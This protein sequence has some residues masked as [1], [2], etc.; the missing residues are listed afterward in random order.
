M[1]RVTLNPKVDAQ[2]QQ[3]VSKR[4]VNDL[5]SHEW[6]RQLTGMGH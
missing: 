3:V 2:I 5:P 4:G 1:R 6:H